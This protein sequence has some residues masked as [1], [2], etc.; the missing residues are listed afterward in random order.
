[1]GG[2]GGSRRPQCSTP[3]R[4]LPPLPPS[5]H[6]LAEILTDEARLER[7]TERE[8]LLSVPENLAHGPSVSLF[9]SVCL[10]ACLPPCLSACV[11]VSCLP[12]YTHHLNHLWLHTWLFLFDVMS[13]PSLNVSVFAENF[14]FNCFPEHVLLHIFV[15]SCTAITTSIRLSVYNEPICSPLIKT[16]CSFDWKDCETGLDCR[17]VHADVRFDYFCV[18]QEVS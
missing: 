12:T 6:P 14:S 1:M 13:V 3:P 4:Q 18:Q 16:V 15:H 2:R 9:V 7:E 8:N 5:L 10:F 11:R 17:R